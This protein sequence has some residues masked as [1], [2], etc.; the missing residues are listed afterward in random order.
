MKILIVSQYFWPESFRINEVVHDLQKSGHVVEVLTG[1]PN[2]PEG[3]FYSGYGSLK[4]MTQIWHEIPVYR[5][6][7]IARGKNNRL[8]LVLNYLSFIFSGLI[9]APFM[10]RKRRFD[11]IFVYA[12]SPIFQVI[13]ASLLGWLKRI[14]VV[15]WVQDLWPQSVSATG[16]IQSA[17]ILKILEKAVSLAYAHTDLIL[18]Q[19]QAFIKHIQHLSPPAVPVKY[20]PNSV[21]DSFLSPETHHRVAVPLL[22]SGF[23]VMFAG[24]IG[25]A[26]AIETIVGAAE[27]LKPYEDIKFVMLGRGSKLDWLN[28]EIS[29][30]GL[31]N[32]IIGGQYPI[33]D[34]PSLLRQASALLVT[35]SK[36]PIFALTIPSKIQAYLA[37]GKP[38]IACIDGEG[39]RIIIEANAGVAVPAE[40][41]ELLV[42][43]ILRLYQSKQNDLEKM[44][45]NGQNYFKMHFQHKLVMNSLISHLESAIHQKARTL[46]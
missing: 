2:Y 24:N 3:V 6:P 15:L 42:E 39:A 10:L 5:I 21:D 33:E 36:Q 16:H 12:P 31:D 1:K 9:F 7:V 26:Q 22:E 44:G 32:I 25:S 43:A 23:N 34:M 46:T 13:P 29:K 28:V 19:S 27:K 41:V 30:R 40:N 38:I 8:K 18:A 4:P 11:V 14:P 17:F 35:L 37:A 45:L 20:L